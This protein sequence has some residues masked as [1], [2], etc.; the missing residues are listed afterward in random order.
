MNS[1]RSSKKFLRN[2]SDLRQVLTLAVQAMRAPR[3]TMDSSGSILNY[4]VSIPLPRALAE[5]SVC[6]TEAELEAKVRRIAQVEVM[7][8]QLDLKKE[9][10]TRTKNMRDF[11]ST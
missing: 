9:L 3:P 10:E 11:V 5:S 6:P 7:R 4:M 1:G 8:T 2:K